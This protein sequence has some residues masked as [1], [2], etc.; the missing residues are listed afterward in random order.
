MNFTNKQW[1]PQSIV[2]REKGE[3]FI[4]FNELWS[5]LK[6][7]TDEVRYLKARPDRDNNGYP[8]QETE[9]VVL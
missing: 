2:N 4:C 9:I 3:V 8:N 6:G 5:S 7:D 1:W